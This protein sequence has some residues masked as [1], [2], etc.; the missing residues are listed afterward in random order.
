MGLLG[1][2]FIFCF[3]LP[4]IASLSGAGGEETKNTQSPAA[5]IYDLPKTLQN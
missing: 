5:I 4:A 3:R 1:F 2:I